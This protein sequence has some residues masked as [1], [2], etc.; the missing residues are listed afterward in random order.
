MYSIKETLHSIGVATQDLPAYVVSEAAAEKSKIQSKCSTC[1]GIGHNSKTCP[2]KTTA[3]VLNAD[4]NLRNLLNNITRGEGYTNVFNSLQPPDL[5]TLKSIDAPYADHLTFLQDAMKAPPAN[6]EVSHDIAEKLLEG[7]DDDD[8]D[9]EEEEGIVQEDREL[10][11]LSVAK[12]TGIDEEDEEEE[13][14]GMNESAVPQSQPLKRQRF[15]SQR[16]VTLQCMCGCN[17]EFPKDQI[18]KCRKCGI[19]NIKIDHTTSWKCKTCSYL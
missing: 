19:V 6:A 12:H 1:K 16:D 8:D 17:N 13:Q 7:Q 14:D 4:S 11:M 2:K 10:D 15:T 9:E 5:S 3:T 18:I